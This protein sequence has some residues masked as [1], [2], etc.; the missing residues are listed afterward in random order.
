MVVRFIKYK[1]SL[2]KCHNSNINYTCENNSVLF[3]PVLK[4]GCAEDICK[5]ETYMMQCTDNNIYV[6]LSERPLAY[7][8]RL[9]FHIHT[10]PIQESIKFNSLF[11]SFSS[12]TRKFFHIMDPAYLYSE[13]KISI[14]TKEASPL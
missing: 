4:L 2:D 14:V 1:N 7:Y 9:N 3:G 5:I 11:S 10:V 13:S 6:W 12:T 8:T